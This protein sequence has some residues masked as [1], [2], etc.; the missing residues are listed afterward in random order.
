MDVLL[1]QKSGEHAQKS[2]T[3]SQFYD[4]S[5]KG[6][7]KASLFI[8]YGSVHITEKLFSPFLAFIWLYP[9]ILLTIVNKNTERVDLF[10][11]YA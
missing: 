4:F 5:K 2:L 11:V 8:L 10:T 7:R 9:R 1:F 3:L 6:L